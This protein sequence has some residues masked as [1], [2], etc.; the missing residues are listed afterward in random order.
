MKQTTALITGAA[1]GIGL[2]VAKRLAETGHDLYLLDRS[3][4][5]EAITADLSPNAGKVFTRVAD[6]SKEE[7]IV[8]ATKD[9]IEKLGGVAI[10]VNCAGISPKGNGGPVPLEEIKV[11]DWEYCHRINL[12]APFV[13][14]RELIPQMAKAGYGRVVSISSRSARMHVGP[15]SFDYHSSKA[16][17]LGFSRALAGTYA[18]QGV[19]VN[20][21]APGRVDTPL[22]RTTRPELLEHA[23]TLIPARRFASPDEIA[24]SVQFLV[25]PDASYITGSCVDVNGGAYMN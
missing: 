12:V 23:K 2:A 5:I 22:S 24:A 15:A 3:P 6:V 8:A 14:C 13:F 10:L 17:L 21:V 1:S 16:G 11:E 7:E 19:T 20:C 18:E 25:S 4:N 9:A